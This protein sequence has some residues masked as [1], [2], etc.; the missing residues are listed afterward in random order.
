MFFHDVICPVSYIKVDSN[1]SRV[2][3]FMNSVL[4]A[5][6]LLS[7]SPYFV[8][9][10]AFDYGIRAIWQL[11]YSPIRFL[12]V[13][14][15]NALDIPVKP[16]DQAPKLFASRVGFLFAFTST[17]LFP[18]SAMASL[19]VAGVLLVFTV[20]DSVF[21]FCVGCLV[22]TYVVLSIYKYM[23]IRETV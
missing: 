17:L 11:K 7:G 14:L 21:D 3:V 15:T 20:L 18:V 13:K 1:V 5:L 4:L 8:A 22:Y 12:A 10:V 2:T 6:Y 16:I 19:G 23:G 9:I